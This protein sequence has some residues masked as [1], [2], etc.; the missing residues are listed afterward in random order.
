MTLIIKKKSGNLSSVRKHKNTKCQ[1]WS[2]FF[3]LNDSTSTEQVFFYW[4]MRCLFL[5]K[6]EM[7]S[8]GVRLIY[9]NW[10]T[11]T[12][13]LLRLRESKHYDSRLLPHLSQKN[14]LLKLNEHLVPVES[15]ISK[16][17]CAPWLFHDLV[18]LMDLSHLLTL[19]V[20]FVF[21]F[22]LCF[23]FLYLCISL[24]SLT[25]TVGS[26]CLS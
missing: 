3:L 1:F 11:F 24:L 6:S 14:H 13:V 20:I 22:P 7:M 10:L 9:C 26:V 19:A 18:L 8:A 21:I 16:V 15:M 23:I 12:E 2:F 5:Q 4:Q 25:P 17:R